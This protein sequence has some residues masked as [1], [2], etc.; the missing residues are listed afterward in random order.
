MNKDRPEAA[1]ASTGEEAQ[2][3][4]TRPS[5]YVEHF[6]FRV[7]Q[8]ALTEATAIYWK[9]RAEALERA[10]PRRD[11]FHGAATREDLRERYDALQRD[12][13]ACRRHA[14]LLA[15]HTIAP[16]GAAEDVANVMQEAS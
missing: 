7:L 4:G 12:I 8:D 16:A 13:L 14:N 10:L 6:R 1:L 11:D 5:A 9:R 2:A 3:H 15:S